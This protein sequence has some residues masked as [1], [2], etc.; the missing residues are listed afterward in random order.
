MGSTKLTRNDLG[1][2]SHRH[3]KRHAT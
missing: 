3:S 1:Y 2:D